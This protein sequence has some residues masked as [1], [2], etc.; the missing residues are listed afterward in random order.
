[1]KK[2]IFLVDD[3]QNIL[4][5]VSMA[6]ESEGFSV[7]TFTD[8][9]KGLKG[10]LG[11]SPDIAVLDIKMP[12]LNGI[13]LLKKLRGSSDIPVIFLTSKDTEIDQLLGFKLGADDYITKPF[14]QKILIE[15]IRV[16]IKRQELILNQDKVLGKTNI[17]TN[18]TVKGNFF[19]DKDKHI[20]KWKNKT[21]HLTV[22]EFLII[23]SLIENPGVVKSREQLM[24]AAFG[25]ESKD[26]DDRAIDH[27]L[28]RI[29]KKIKIFDNKFNSIHTIYGIGYKFSE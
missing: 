22:T 14:S 5:S 2:K 6:L 17:K 3:D 4:T 26:E 19:L 21:I 25:D 23:R 10:I 15:R 1:M 8:G 13:D 29:R 28:K 20:C 18:T 27:H 24:M 12:R 7:K 9:E 11:E 16:L